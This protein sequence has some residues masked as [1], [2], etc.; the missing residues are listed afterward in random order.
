MMAA[1]C[2]SR[3]DFPPFHLDLTAGRL[4]RDGKAV[5]LPPK[6]L[7]VLRHLAERP[8]QLVSKEA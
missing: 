5:D 3:I 1:A 6:A 7:A 8:G 4:V 2:V